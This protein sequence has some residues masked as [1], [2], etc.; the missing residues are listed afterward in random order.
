MRPKIDDTWFGSITVAGTRYEHDIII[1]LS[2]RIRKRNKQLSKTVYGHSHTISLA[3]IKDLYRENA[4]RIIIGSG[5]DGQ[6]RLSEEASEF[7]KKHGCRVDLWPTPE[8]IHH[9]NKA[10][11][12]VLGLFHVTS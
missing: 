3:E 9:W 4:E 8:A 12:K 2:S 7:L 6:V 10:E 5:Q 11:G 1:R